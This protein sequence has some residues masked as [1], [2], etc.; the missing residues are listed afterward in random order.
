MYHAPVMKT[1]LYRYL[2]REISVPFLLG[3]TIFTSVLLMGRLLK[4]ADMVVAKGVPLSDVLWMVVY[5]LPYFCLVTIPMAILLA[6]LLA[7][8]RL[9]ADSEITAMKACGI[10]LYGL[11]PPVLVFALFAYLATTVVTVYGIPWGNTSFRLLVTNILEERGA[12]ALKEQVFMDDF[13]GM[14]IYLNKYSPEDHRISGILIQDE[15]NPEETSTIFATAGA[16]QVDPDT[17]V[18]RI[19]LQN[20][21][22]HRSFGKTGYRLVEFRGYDLNINLR[23]VSREILKNELDMSLAELRAGINTPYLTK[24]LRTDMR[25][26]VQRRFSL[27]FACFVFALVGIPLGIQNQRSGKGAGFTL[28]IGVLIIYYVVLS[29][30]RTLG[31]RELIT[32]AVAMWTPNVLFIIFG[33]YL[34]RQT[35]EERQLYLFT[36][37]TDLGRRLRKKLSPRRAS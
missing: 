7:F 18:M 32:A 35:A 1:T 28:S 31:E 20:G 29:I 5:L 12:S 33:V 22:I 6:V 15:R 14:V 27:P 23:Q 24:R 2:F 8:G 13:P 19:H 36:A 11:L 26:E 3:M 30:F 34:F 9:S 4:L 10:S 37:L 16:I 17:R 21:S 25:L